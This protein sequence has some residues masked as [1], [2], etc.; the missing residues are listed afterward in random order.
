M[1]SKKVFGMKMKRDNDWAHF[2]SSRKSPLR[3]HGKIDARNP[4]CD[5]FAV[6]EFVLVCWFLCSCVCGHPVVCVLL[7]S[8]AFSRLMSRTDGCQTH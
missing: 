5:L 3:S 6:G 1:S 7:S 2:R 8:A 4:T